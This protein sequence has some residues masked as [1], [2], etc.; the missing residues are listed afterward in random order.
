MLRIGGLASGLDVDSMVTQLIRAHSM[1]IDRMVQQKQT[2]EWQ[3]DAYR[4]MNLKMTDFRNNKLSTYRLQGTFID[5]KANITGDQSTVSAK[6]VGNIQGSALTLKVNALATAAAKWSDDIR[7]GE[8]ELDVNKALSQQNGALDGDEFTKSDYTIKINGQEVDINVEKD[9]LQN[10]IDKINKETD[11]TAFYDD[12]TGRISFKSDN[13]GAVNGPNNE[14]YIVFEDDD[15]FL[16]NTFKIDASDHETNSVKATN[17]DV[18][19]NGMQTYR[20]SNVFVV[21]GIEVTLLE[22]TGQ[23]VM[24]NIARDTDKIFNVVMDFVN[25]YNEMIDALNSKI[26]EERH[27]DYHPLTEEQKNAMTDR[28]VDRWEEMAKSGMLKN[29]PILFKLINTMRNI[30]ASSVEL[31]DGKFISL[32]SLGIKTGSYT[33]RGRLH[34]DEFA[35]REA[36]EADPD[37]VITLFTKQGNQSGSE[38]LGIS[39]QGIGTALY[40]EFKLSLDEIVEKAGSPLALVNNSFI[41]E[42][43]KNMNERIDA[44]NRRLTELEERYYRQFSAMEAAMHQLNSQSV[45]LANMFNQG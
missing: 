37:A 42:S 28:E 26:G 4:E 16:L 45:A 38:K 8:G 40:A 15:N 25:D 44:A 20:E 21:N 9:S 23:E 3:R 39:G 43:I 17:A 6:A 5:Y 2:F 27:R 19:I 36:I 29:D 12:V 24:V 10:V 34:V 11:V 33:E 13:T 30:A 35:L 18:T 22:A 31:E 1:P 32:H 41:G 7:S 14:A